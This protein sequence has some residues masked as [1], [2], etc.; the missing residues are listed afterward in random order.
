[1]TSRFNIKKAND[2]PTHCRFVNALLGLVGL[3]ALSGCLSP[4]TLNKTV[5]SY[6]RS[7]SEINA[8]ELLLNIA[9]VRHHHPIQ[10]TAVS[11]IAATFNFQINAGAVP[12]FGALTGGH[13]L[14]PIFGG[15]ISENPTI[16]ITPINGEEFNQRILTPFSESKFFNIY[17]QGTD[18]GLLLRMMAS[19]FRIEQKSSDGI[20]R[21]RPRSGNGYEEFRRRAL[22]LTA[23]NQ[24]HHLHI[25]PIV[26]QQFITLPTKST[27]HTETLVSA[28][29]KGY[30]WVE[31]GDTGTLS[32]NIAGRVVISNYAVSDLSIEER[33][34]L[35]L[36][37]NTLPN[38]EIFVDIRPG[39][40][41]GDYP[42]RGVIRLR[43]FLAILGFLG[44]GVAEEVEFPV[45][46]DVRTG[47]VRLNPAK[48]LEVE[49]GSANSSKGTFSISYGDKTYSILDGNNPEAVWN[50]ESFRLLS[51][52]YQLSVQPSEF[53]KPP[54]AITIAK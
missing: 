48:T 3:L 7:I 23:L 6:N 46:K 20:L 31:D 5:L 21:N 49:D 36:Y 16:S 50:L 1:M 45:E 51:Q 54:P 9:R 38:N 53:A 8:Q 47:E 15:S 25:E 26:I 37:T 22:H 39:L 14:A 29:E 41:G 33:N 40:P 24:S 32:R 19:E 17:Q 44:R 10:F 30:R 27:E 11:S 43:A 52:L 12:P 35:Y 4:I 28:L 18:F 13:G 34:K 42:L 2:L